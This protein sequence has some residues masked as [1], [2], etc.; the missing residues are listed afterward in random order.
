MEIKLTQFY[1]TVK[2]VTFIISQYWYF[3]MGFRIYDLIRDTTQVSYDIYLSHHTSNQV[4]IQPWGPKMWNVTE[5]F[6]T[7]LVD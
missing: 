5:P 1:D 7:V 2:A 3:N 4:L 6:K